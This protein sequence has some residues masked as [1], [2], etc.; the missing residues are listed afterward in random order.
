MSNPVDTASIEREAEDLPEPAL[1]LLAQVK[2]GG[3]ELAARNLKRQRFVPFM[4]KRMQRVTAGRKQVDRPRPLFPGYVFVGAFEASPWRA[5][6]GTYGIS[7][8]VTRGGGVP[9]PVPQ[10][11]IDALRARCGPDGL[12]LPPRA[13]SPGDAVRVLTGPF[14]ELV[15]R[16]EHMKEAERVAVLVEM[17]GQAVRIEV[18][19]ETLELI[20]P[21]R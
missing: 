19:A 7:R 11:L 1:W 12:L 4:P 14:A 21:G 15:A 16:V 13:F 20:G 5:I 3:Y 8:L 6:H 18:S 17:M 2:P 10:D 9:Q